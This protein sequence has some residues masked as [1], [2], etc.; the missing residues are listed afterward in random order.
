VD[1]SLGV[2]VLDKGVCNLEDHRNFKL[3]DPILLVVG[4]LLVEDLRSLDNL[5]QFEELRSL[6]HTLVEKGGIQDMQEVAVGSKEEVEL[7]RKAGQ[8]DE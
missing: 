4:S 8:F 6:S 3:V 7:V 2:R 1:N 5:L